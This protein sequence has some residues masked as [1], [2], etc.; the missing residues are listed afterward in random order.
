MN[1]VCDASSEK[2]MFD[3][4]Q[5]SNQLNFSLFS[6]A[7]LPEEARAVIRNTEREVEETLEAAEIDTKNIA[8]QMKHLQYENQTKLGEM[9]AEMMTQLKLSQE[10][11]LQQ[12]NLLLLDKR[13]LRKQLQEKEEFTELCIQ[14]LKM[15]HTEQ[16]SQEKAR[17][18]DEVKELKA[19]HDQ[20]LDATLKESE[21]R[22]AMEMS[23]TEERK[24]SQIQQLITNHEL[25]F[26]EMKRFYS[27][28][29]TNNVALID[30]M[31][32]QMMELSQQSERNE[33]QVADV[34]AHN[35]KLL[36]PLKAAQSETVELKKK[37]EV[38]E[39]DRSALS[40]CSSRY[41]AM[42]KKCDYYKWEC[43]V[44]KMQAEKL[45]QERDTL[46]DNFEV[47][48]IEMQQKT[49]LKNAL[50]ERKLSILEAE[51][52]QTEATFGSAVNRATS[53]DENKAMIEKILAQ[54]NEKIQELRY[55]LAKVSK[56]HEELL[57]SVQA[58]MA[59]FGI[60][61]EELGFEPLQMPR[62]IVLNLGPSG[63]VARNK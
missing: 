54:K 39:R 12:E 24:N 13:N 57:A 31:R 33:K 6:I 28:I 16:M 11:H 56:A 51:K 20:K 3:I 36:E 45:A 62:N 41:S 2:E 17:F 4:F 32:E 47:A 14:Q 46:K 27:A 8:Q 21:I 18:Q 10:D 42:Q 30:S 61:M 38:S 5:T 60:P 22:H 23:E 50:L 29:I 7:S 55:T 52:E 1:W 43:E 59:Q 19:F 37:L 58:K 44:L 34:T 48:L 63:L 40:R 9:R 49:G 25:A 15:K 26:E 35:R 53:G